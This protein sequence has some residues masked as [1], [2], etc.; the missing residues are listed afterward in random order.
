VFEIQEF[1]LKYW[2]QALFGLFI[3]GLTFAVKKLFKKV[4]CDRMEQKAMKDG[5][6]AI[7]HNNLMHECKR[8]IRQKEITV[9]EMD[10]LKIMYAPYHDLGL[11]GTIKTL[12][13]TAMEQPLNCEEDDSK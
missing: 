11:N 3:T 13:K 1:L 9:E 7:L 2:L 12:Y 5:I 10:N 4:K 6:G 8:I